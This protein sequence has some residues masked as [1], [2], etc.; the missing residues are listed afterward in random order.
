MSQ[1]SGWP[2]KY[3]W[4]LLP[5]SGPHPFVPPQRRDWLKNPLRGPNG[6]YVDARGN[7][8]VPHVGPTGLDHWD[9]QHPNG[10]HT[11]VRTDGNI[12]HGPNHF[13]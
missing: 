7:E 13:P 8:W 12:H 6:G 9:V 3:P 1:G 10:S 5:H 4:N 2:A 11:N